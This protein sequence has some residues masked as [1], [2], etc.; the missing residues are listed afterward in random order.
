[1]PK[2]I[3][4]VD[5]HEVVR[6]GVRLV[7]RARPEWQVV[8]EA[9]NPMEAIQ[10]TKMHKP[11]LAILDISMPGRDGIE[12]IKDLTSIGT[13]ILVLTMHHSNELLLRIRLSGA[14]GYV[15]KT[16]ASRDLLRA[17]EQTFEGGT[18]FPDQAL[19]A[20]NKYKSSGKSHVT[21]AASPASF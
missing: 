15:V 11:D 12:V 3:L 5:D 20:R 2:R 1:M 19:S 7:L 9:E 21:S 10:K 4:L 16:C 8:D 18:F 17:I 14:S 13:K 6:Q